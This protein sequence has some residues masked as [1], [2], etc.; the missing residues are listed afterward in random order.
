VLLTGAGAP[1]ALEE[2]WA[3]WKGEVLATGWVEYGQFQ[4]RRVFN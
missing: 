2:C 3:S 4:P 1:V